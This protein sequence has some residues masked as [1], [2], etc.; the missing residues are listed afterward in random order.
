[1]PLLQRRTA[2]RT[3]HPEATVRAVV[4]E[5]FAQRP[6]VVTVP[7]PKP[8]TDGVVLRVEATGLC[9]SDWHGWM[10]HDSDIR[11]P[12]VPGHEIAGIV[13]ATGDRVERWRIGDRVTVPF[14]CACGRCAQ[15]LRGQQQ[16]CADQRQ[17]GFTD[18]GSFAEYVAIA[19]ADLNLVPLPDELAFDA[20]AALGCR[21]GT[22]FHAV[23][24]QAKVQAGETVAVHG[25]GGLGLATV[26]LAAAAGARVIAVDV[27]AGALVLAAQIGARA[28]VHGLE[29]D[30]VGAITDL[31][32]ADVS[33]D[34]VGS[35]QTAANSVLCLAARGRHVQVGLLPSA[36][37]V[38]RV[39]MDRVIAREL[40][41]LGSHGIAAHE[42]PR[43]LGMICDGRV[44]PALLLGRHITLD[45]VPDALVAM[46]GA[47]PHGVTIIEPG[48]SPV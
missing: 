2:A 21:F 36:V 15:C 22:A 46:T 42:Y 20:A 29:V 16:I 12:H 31:G 27:D 41:L 1:V 25:C 28:T 19:R 33:F 30:V 47:A 45:E 13:A 34:C 26:L 11:L 23:F 14:V 8:A 32:C 17:P 44:D 38:P 4:Y 10:G 48:S 6:V 5:Q 40:H 18:W 7:D 37:R 24:A 43:M 35:E 39:P 3:D 9:R